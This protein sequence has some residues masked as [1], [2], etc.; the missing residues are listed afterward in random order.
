MYPPF[1]LY[2]SC[3]SIMVIGDLSNYTTGFLYEKTSIK[4]F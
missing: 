4:I 3:V 2:L 1:I